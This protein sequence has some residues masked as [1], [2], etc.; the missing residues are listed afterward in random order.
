MERRQQINWVVCSTNP[1]AILCTCSV[2]HFRIAANS[3]ATFET[4]QLNADGSDTPLSRLSGQTRH[5]NA[6]KASSKAPSDGHSL[7]SFLSTYTSEDNNSFQELI[8]S[9]DKRLRQKFSVLYDA[10]KDT[11]LAI[12]NS[13]TVPSIEQ[14]F[15]PID[16]P[17]S[18]CIF[19]SFS[20][21]HSIDDYFDVF[22]L[23]LETWK[24]KN[25][26]YI[27]YVPDGVDLTREEKLEM[28]KQKQEIDYSNT[29]LNQMP[30]DEQANKNAM[31]VGRFILHSHS[32]HDLIESK[33]IQNFAGQKYN[34]SNRHRWQSPDC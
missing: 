2:Y 7:D 4:P 21:D 28:A 15:E 27:M 33:L 19:T 3:P 31:Q 16:G 5:S 32:F 29:R 23:Q 22:A 20:S 34:R 9:A 8:E 14:Q 1:F 24:Y 10:E 12:A 6:S 17:K 11:A 18:V 25:K 30:F 13:L 26:N